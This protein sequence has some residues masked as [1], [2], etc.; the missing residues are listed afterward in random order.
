MSDKK[1]IAAIVTSYSPHSHADVL[2]P[3]FLKGF[4]ADEGLM[5]PKVELA[6]MYLDQIHER[7]VGV[8]LGSDRLSLV[9]VL[10]LVVPIPCAKVGVGVVLVLVVGLKHRRRHD[11]E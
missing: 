3:K 9:L 2:I 10:V 5:P 4:P 1:K 8:G 6:S 11:R 7:D